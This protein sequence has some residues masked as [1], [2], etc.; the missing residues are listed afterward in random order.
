MW[1][2]RNDII[3]GSLPDIEMVFSLSVDIFSLLIVLFSCIADS[4]SMI[5]TLERNFRRDPAKKKF[6]HVP[7]RTPAFF[8]FVTSVVVNTT[9][10]YEDADVLSI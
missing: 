9:L 10:K 2:D 4:F 8:P 1:N 6:S 3:P 7:L 5:F